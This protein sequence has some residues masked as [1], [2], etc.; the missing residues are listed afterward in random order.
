MPLSEHELAARG[1]RRAEQ[2]GAALARMHSAFSEDFFVPALAA[3][4]EAATLSRGL[5]AL[6]RDVS[7]AAIEEAD[8][9]VS[10]KWRIAETLLDE[11]SELV[12]GFP[13][14]VE[15]RERIAHEQREMTVSNALADVDAFLQA[16]DLPQARE[17]L[18]ISLKKYPGDRRLRS[19]LQSCDMIIAKRA[20]EERQLRVAGEAD[21][22]AKAEAD[23][24]LGAVRR[25]LSAEPDLKKREM[26]LSAAGKEFPSNAHLSEQLELVKGVQQQVAAI[27][28]Q[29]RECEGRKLFKDA[30]AKWQSLRAIDALYPSLEG[31]IG[32][33]ELA[34]A[35]AVEI[36]TGEHET[37]WQKTM[38]E[39]ERSVPAFLPAQPAGP[40]RIRITLS[41]AENRV[42]KILVPSTI[43]LLVSGLIFLSLR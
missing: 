30:L 11:A 13:D 28:S 37:E 32:R 4:R 40:H 14:S 23:E 33:C 12:P 21:V 8:H 6:E 26:I 42:L 17:S 10:P 41:R 35:P 27:V 3:F 2:V 36:D 1:D 29:A 22:R 43:A 39:V 25:A 5:S 7:S 20:D 19:I 16:G 9:L 34:M 31:E 18:S 24:Q 38:R 15:L